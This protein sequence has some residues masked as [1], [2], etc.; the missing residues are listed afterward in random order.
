MHTNLSF[1]NE[2]LVCSCN[3]PKLD[4]WMNIGYIVITSM[5][6]KGEPQSGG[7]G[8]FKTILVLHYFQ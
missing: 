8:T 3:P 2:Y 6:G 4:K 5:P 7:G 1:D